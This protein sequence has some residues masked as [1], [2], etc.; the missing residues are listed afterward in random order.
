L[1]LCGRIR[2]FNAS[3]QRVHATLRWVLLGRTVPIR[4]LLEAEP[5]AFKPDDVRVI[6][7]AFEQVLHM[8]RLND[9]A[10]PVVL[11]VAELTIEAARRGE[12]D[13]TRLCEAV[14]SRISL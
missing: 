6:V 11:M 2:K 13:P 7:Q 10:D 9:R 12:R 5:L 14:L 4:P 8:K 1:T 3:T